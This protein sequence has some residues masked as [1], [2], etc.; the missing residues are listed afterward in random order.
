VASLISH[1][2]SVQFWENLGHLC[3]R[4]FAALILTFGRTRW[5]GSV[6]RKASAYTGQHSKERRGQTPT[7]CAGF[8]SSISVTLV[9]RPGRNYRFL[10]IMAACVAS[11][12]WT[13]RKAALKME[14]VLANHPLNYM[15]SQSRGPQST[16][17]PS[18]EL[19]ISGTVSCECD[20]T[21]DLTFL[22]RRSY[23]CW[24]SG[25]L[26]GCCRWNIL[27]SSSGWMWGQYFLLSTCLPTNL[28]AAFIGF[29]WFSSDSRW[30]W[31]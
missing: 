7:P 9:K 25:S 13:S 1:P 3:P 15:D 4:G 14:A 24:S 31:R 20:C 12:L 11:P 30:R 17:P 22:W 16:C 29:V 8:D 5:R 27:P 19:Q 26:C 28:Q 2:V 6:L 21:L 23:R 10:P 18:W